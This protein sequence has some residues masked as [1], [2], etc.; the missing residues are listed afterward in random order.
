M[1][2]LE[3]CVPGKVYH[4]NFKLGKIL[5]S[6]TDSQ[7][8]DF[9][10]STVRTDI[11]SKWM[12]RWTDLHNPLHGAGYCL[13]PEFHSH[14]HTACAEALADL[15]TMCDKIHGAGSAA[16]RRPRRRRLRPRGRAAA[17]RAMVDAPKR[18]AG[19][20]VL[21]V[22]G[23][24]VASSPPCRWRPCGVTWDPVPEQSW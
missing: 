12:A 3:K 20:P 22:A 10:P 17:A 18:L 24:L 11:Q 23:W 14:D 21:T 9:I 13:D 2:L 1:N 15:F 16:L 6:M 4:E 5:Q 19:R 7:E 8:F